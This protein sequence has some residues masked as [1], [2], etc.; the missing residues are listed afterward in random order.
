[1]TNDCSKLRIPPG[2]GRR[3]FKLSGERE[4]RCFVT[5]RGNEL[6]ANRQVV[7][8]DVERKAHCRL[9]SHVEE[10]RVRRLLK[11]GLRKVVEG[12]L[13]E[14][15][16]RGPPEKREPGPLGRLERQLADAGRWV[17]ERRRCEQIEGAVRRRRKC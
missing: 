8:I 4:E 1:M 11:G 17:G 2:P 15:T 3:R 12:P 5:E 10:H 14:G 13:K 6:D 16:H 9:P 7:A